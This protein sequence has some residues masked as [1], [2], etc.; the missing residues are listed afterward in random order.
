MLMQLETNLG[1]GAGGASIGACFHIPDARR[2]KKTPEARG[3]RVKFLAL[4]VT[5]IYSPCFPNAI[6][7]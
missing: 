4:F 6:D 1:C 5:Y 3:F 7:S 2:G